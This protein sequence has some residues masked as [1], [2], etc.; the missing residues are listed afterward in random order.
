MQHR[1]DALGQRIE[2]LEKWLR[3]AMG[4][5]L[6]SIAV[7]GTL[8]M[9][10][11]QATAEL[12]T[13]KARRLVIVDER[14]KEHIRLGELP[15]G[16]PGIALFND[17]GKMLVGIGA[18]PVGLT[19]LSLHDRE[20]RVRMWFLVLPDGKVIFRLNDATGKGRIVF[21]VLPKGKPALRLYDEKG[22]ALF[23]AP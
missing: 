19:A 14:G 20:G 15:D 9:G 8:L 7:V 16:T 5:W 12:E 22:S 2:R 23:K 13:L 18:L 10:Y 3:F 1:P 11:R 21:S 6:I 17:A 4:G